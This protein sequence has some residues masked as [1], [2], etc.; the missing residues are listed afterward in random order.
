[1]SKPRF[2]IESDSQYVYI[3]DTVRKGVLE[4][5][6]TKHKNAMS[7]AEERCR[8]LNLQEDRKNENKDKSKTV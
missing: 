1:M 8:D 4:V 5:R 2:V 3:M 7:D 6:E